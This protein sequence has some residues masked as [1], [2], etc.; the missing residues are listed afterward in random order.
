MVPRRCSSRSRARR[1]RSSTAHPFVGFLHSIGQKPSLFISS[2]RCAKL[3]TQVRNVAERHSVVSMSSVEPGIDEVA[4]DLADAGDCDGAAVAGRIRRHR[5]RQ[6]RAAPRRSASRPA[7][8]RLHA[9][10]RRPRRSAGRPARR[11]TQPRD[12]QPL[13]PAVPALVPAGSDR[14]RRRFRAAAAV[15][16]RSDRAPRAARDGRPPRHRRDAEAPRQDAA[17]A[18]PAAHPPQHEP[19]GRGRAR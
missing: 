5:P 9:R 10:L 14:G 12:A 1:L 2:V 3:E 11:R 7:R 18:A 8:P 16:H 13:H 19:A 4:A 6:E 17:P 15:A